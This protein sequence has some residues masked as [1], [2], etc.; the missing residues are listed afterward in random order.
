M[1][2]GGGRA[3]S[4]RDPHAFRALYDAFQGLLEADFGAG[5]GFCDDFQPIFGLFTHGNVVLPCLI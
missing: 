4:R 1:G 5:Q 2:V 3:V